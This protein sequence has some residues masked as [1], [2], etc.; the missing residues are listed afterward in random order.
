MSP[1]SRRASGI[2]I[3]DTFGE[4]ILLRAAGQGIDDDWH[5]CTMF[6][7]ST[8]RPA[9]SADTRLFVPPVLPA[10][11]ES[12]PLEKVLLLRDEMANMAW[13]VE[14]TVQTRA[15][16]DAD[17]YEV[18]RAHA[19]V[20]TPPVLHPT[21]APVRYVLGT[22]VPENWRP[23]IPVHVPGSH[24]TIRL[25]RARMPGPD[26]ELLGRILTEP[27]PYYIHE[28][29]VPRSGRIVTRTVQRLRWL[30]GRTFV[31]IGR[32]VLTGRGEASTGLAFDQVQPV[33]DS[34][35]VTERDRRGRSTQSTHQSR[36][37]EAS[38]SLWL[39]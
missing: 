7:L 8:D 36:W 16:T 3:T 28:E 15:G 37:L 6:T 13:A 20:S 22:H 10:G 23:L 26:R 32:R 21:V 27:T 18:A 2:I 4:R 1:R 9:G 31:W 17:G 29:E 24:R 12:A 5:R 25:Q 39:A 34:E 19:P 33:P 11:M 38:R 35:R 30:G 14:R